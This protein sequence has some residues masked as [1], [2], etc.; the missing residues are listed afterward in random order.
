MVTALLAVVLAEHVLLSL[1]AQI[2]TRLTTTRQPLKMTDRA[3]HR[4]KR[5]HLP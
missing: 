1:V 4:A 2:Q 3:P 5:V